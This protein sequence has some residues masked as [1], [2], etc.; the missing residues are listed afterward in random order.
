MFTFF[1]TNVKS[2][3][4]LVPL[5]DVDGIKCNPITQIPKHADML[6]MIWNIDGETQNA[7]NATY[8]QQTAS[9]ARLLLFVSSL[10]LVSQPDMFE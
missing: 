8:S 3:N 4:L 5:V 10:A 6:H 7:A 2:T 1:S 9:V